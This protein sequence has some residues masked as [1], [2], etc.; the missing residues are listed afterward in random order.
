MPVNPATAALVTLE[1]DRLVGKPHMLASTCPICGS[2]EALGRHGDRCIL[3]AGLVE[4]GLATQVERAELREKLEK[5]EEP[6]QT[7][8]RV[9]KDEGQDA[10]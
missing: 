7:D 8:L 9:L 5:S 10:G 4:L 2:L 6:T 3:D 1:W